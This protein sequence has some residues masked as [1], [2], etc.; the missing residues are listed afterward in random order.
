MTKSSCAA[1]L[2][3]A[4]NLFVA[5]GAFAATPSTTGVSPNEAALVNRG[6][7][8]ARAGDC[9]ACHTGKGGKP[10]AG[11]LPISSP[12]GV[13]YSTNITPDPDTGIGRYTYEDFDR[14]LRHG[15]AK[16]GYTLY[17][18]M[19]YPSYA[20]VAP[21]DVK[22]LYAYFMHGVTP[23]HQSQQ[24]NG[25]PWP[26]SIRW[27]LA[28]WRRA[29]AP[30]IT[31]EVAPEAAPYGTG[32]DSAMRARG[33]YLVE[34]LGHCS[35]CHTSRG[36][37]LEEKALTDGDGA[38]FLG[39]SVVE[40]WYANNLHADRASGLGDWSREDIVAF[41][42]SGRNDH[43]AAFGGMR[44]VVL[45][46]TQYLSDSDLEAMAA[47]LESLKPVQ[48]SAPAPVFSDTAAK[49]LH[50]GMTTVPGARTFLDN[51]AACHRSDGKGY[52]GVFP[53]LA[54][55]ST[56]DASDPSSLIHIVLRGSAMPGTAS[57]PTV[58]TMP[59]FAQRLTDEQVAEVVSFIRSAWGNQAGA[60]SADEVRKVRSG[61]E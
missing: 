21:A 51:C 17:P 4:A 16:D 50:A 48:G 35:A 15:I 59:G 42:K 46:S 5:G 58:F 54:L 3:L 26:L 45:N 49:M 56:V 37:L 52:P 60:V 19:P 29:F 44:D 55:S 6:E 8:L 38:A 22:A 14:A 43:S 1:A 9:I 25:I 27:P 30:V 41:L 33:R 13:I 32:N 31:S 10:F 24:A 40:H 20:R 47:Y 18:A 34:G 61:T 11:G 2:V 36:A 23:V 39:G 57:A 12:I 28:L 7:Y 53:R